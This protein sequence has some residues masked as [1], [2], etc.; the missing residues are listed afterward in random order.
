MIRSGRDRRPWER[1]LVAAV[2][3]ATALGLVA[4]GAAPPDQSDAPSGPQGS[5]G[6]GSDAPQFDHVHGMGA[7][8]A[9]GTVYVATHDGLFRA[10]GG[11]L[12]RVGTSGRDLMGFTIT[13]PKSFLSSGHPGPGE[14]AP[15]PLGV[16]QSADAGATWSPLGLT[17]E[18]DFHALEVRGGVVYGYDATNRVLRASSDGGRSW[19][20]R[21]ELL[22]LDITAEPSNPATVLATVPG[23]VASSLDGGRTF[24]APT[25]PQ[26]AYL[27]WAPD[28]VV[29]GIGLDGAL[30]ASTDRGLSWEQ[31]GTAPGG[32]PQALTAIPDPAASTDLLIATAGGLFRSQD[33]GRS[34]VPLA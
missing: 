23:G 31:R 34:V 25:G 24:N 6:D 1:T 7:D 29:Y 13:G 30:F 20:S 16:V 22:A 3:A 27:S 17:G 19:S 33:A 14:Q 15:N 2:V 12:S 18:V 11:P 26:L 32:R 5:A 9:D 8:P 10:A 28:G 21:S 4:C